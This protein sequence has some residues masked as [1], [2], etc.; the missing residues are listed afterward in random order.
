MRLARACYGYYVQGIVKR[1]FWDTTAYV[2]LRRHHLLKRANERFH[3]RL[4][5]DR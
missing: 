3:F 1:G 4:F 5:P 2:R